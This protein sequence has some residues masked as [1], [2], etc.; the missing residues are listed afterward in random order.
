MKIKNILKLIIVTIIVLIAFGISTVSNAVVESNQ[1]KITSEG[2]K[3]YI[4]GIYQST[5][6]DV[7]KKNIITAK[8]VDVYNSKNQ[9]VEDIAIIETGNKIKIGEEEYIAIVCG[10]TNGDGKAGLTDLVNIKQHLIGKEQLTNEKEVAADIDVSKKVTSTDILN[11]KRLIV[12]IIEERQIYEQEYTNEE[13][14]YRKNKLTE[15]VT[16]IKLANNK[17][18]GVLQIPNKIDGNEVTKIEDFLGEN[19]RI[20]KVIIPTNIEDICEVAF[21][22]MEKVEAIEVSKLNGNYSSKEGVLYSKDGTKLIT[23]PRGK[24]EEEYEIKDTVKEIGE[25]AFYKNDKIENVYIPESV[26]KVSKTSFEEMQGKVYVKEG[27]RIKNI[28]DKADV[29]YKVDIAPKVTK[30]TYNIGTNQAV[31]VTIEAS[32][33]EGIIAWSITKKGSTQEK[34]KEISSTTSLKTTYT[35][36]AENGTYVLKVKDKA[37]N[38]GSKEITITELDESKPKVTSMKV[39]SPVSGEYKPGQKIVVRVEFSEKIKGTAP[40]LKLKIGNE[41][42]T[43][44][45]TSSNVTGNTKYIDYTYTSNDKQAGKVEIYSY[46]GGNLTDLKG[47]KLIINK[48]ANTGNNITMINPEPPEVNLGEFNAYSYESDWRGKKKTLGYWLYV[49]D[50]SI[51]KTYKDIPLIVYL[52]GS[53]RCGNDINKVVTLVTSLPRFIKDKKVQPKAIVVMPQCPEGHD[54]YPEVVMSLIN[55]IKSNFDINENKIALTGHSLGGNG[56]WNVAVGLPNVFSVTVPVSLWVHGDLGPVSDL[57]NCR[58]RFIYESSGYD[59]AK[60]RANAYINKVIQ[61]KGSQYSRIIT[62]EVIPKTN[63]ETVA[64]VYKDT[65]LIQWMINQTRGKLY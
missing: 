25:H 23:F 43:G 62:M 64:N 60:K 7:F 19:K 4:L 17:K 34:W 38:I 6:V 13:Y 56:A 54:W 16:I 63:H 2:G 45:M 65:D 1:Y 29:I 50:L 58:V 40:T 5:R 48:L 47:N 12:R 22:G 18:S 11:L 14:E 20:T 61:E 32:D 46:S 10:D 53:S 37:G 44:S 15:K 9:K 3:N 31:T 55:V 26:E 36:I 28:L 27:S 21:S 52:H 8:N 24:K 35:D 33:A 30:L 51:V 57:P 59:E 41:I 49:P 39:I 42:G